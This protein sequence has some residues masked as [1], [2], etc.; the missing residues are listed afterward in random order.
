MQQL[1]WFSQSPWAEVCAD[2][3]S[4]K[5]PGEQFATITK[6]Y[7]ADVAEFW[8][9]HGKI[10]GEKEKNDFYGMNFPAPEQI[11]SKLIALAEKFPEDPAAFEILAW[12]IDHPGMAAQEETRRK[13]FDVL[14]RDHLA[15]EKLPRVFDAANEDFLRTVI[16]KSPHREVRGL[17]CFALAEHQLNRIRM[18]KRFR[19]ENPAWPI[20]KQWLRTVPAFAFYITLD[21]DQATK[22]AEYTLDR[23]VREFADVP[24]EDRRTGKTVGVLA[25]NHLHEIRDLAIGMPAPGLHS[26]N[27]DGQPV[28][29]SDL[30][31]KVVVLDVWATW[32][33]PC[34]AMIPDSRQLVKS[35]A[36]KPF[37]LVSISI[38]D[39][40]QTVRDFW[41]KEP[42]PWTHWYNGPQGPVFADLNACLF[43][44][45]YVIDAKGVIRYKDVRG[46]LLEQAVNSL[47]KEIEDGK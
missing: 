17:A 14:L 47:L 37:E 32:C 16:E 39:D 5:S 21:V 11:N 29:L 8:K 40:P 20:T 35:L 25:R 45:I 27:F 24:I 23:V 9:K 1:I 33:G 46:Q 31:G 6:Q 19:A 41:A 34:C 4:E 3:Q 18:V 2:D 26:T 36:G 10:Q 28:K 42:M 44:T 13:P 22:D 30:K 15:N 43:P 12:V 7:D 38:D